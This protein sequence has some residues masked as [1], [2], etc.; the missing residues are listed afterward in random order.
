MK[1][2]KRRAASLVLA[3]CLLAAALPGARADGAET[4]ISSRAWA[5]WSMTV[6]KRFF[7]P[8]GEQPPWT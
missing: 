3:L 7:M 1:T 8:M 2:F 5:E 4:A 6:S